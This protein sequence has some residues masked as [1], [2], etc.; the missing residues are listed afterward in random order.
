MHFLIGNHLAGVFQQHRQD[1]DGLIGNPDLDS[2]P[3]Q[4]SR[5]QVQLERAK[6][7]KAGWAGDAHRQHSWWASLTQ[8]AETACSCPAAQTTVEGA[9][10]IAL[11]G[12]TDL[13]LWLSLVGLGA[14]PPDARSHI[15]VHIYNYRVR[16][17]A[18]R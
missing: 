4:L 18:I 15:E 13:S 7:E 8:T 3:A 14:Q 5:S 16:P 6:A 12:F 17:P 1:L 11:N 2:V 9:M 10:S